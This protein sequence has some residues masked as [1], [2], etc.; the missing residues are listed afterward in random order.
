MEDVHRL[1]W[2]LEPEA[3]RRAARR[4]TDAEL[5][6]AAEIEAEMAVESD[7]E[8]WSQ[9][10]GRFHQ[11]FVQAAGSERLTKFLKSLQD[12]FAMYILASHFMDDSR[13]SIANAQH[14]DL[15]AAMRARD[16]DR[17]VA[18]MYDHMRETFDHVGHMSLFQE[19]D[20]PAEDPHDATVPDAHERAG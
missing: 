16:A 7:P 4:V 15:L 5:E 8:L 20:V 10:N 17:A 14:K 11:V 3:L 12:G 19:P 18:V 9:L 6:R 13:R 1:R 2:L